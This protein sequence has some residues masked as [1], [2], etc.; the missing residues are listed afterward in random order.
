MKTRTLQI[1]AGLAVFATA[2]AATGL[3]VKTGLWEVTYT[4]RV[5]GSLIPKDVLDAMPPDRRAKVEQAM[6]A[7]SNAPPQPHKNQT[8][9]TEDDL[10]KGA[11]DPEADSSCQKAVVSQTAAH[12]EITMQCKDQHGT[13]TGHM[14]L[15]ATNEETIKGKVEIVTAEGKINTQVDGRWLDATCPDPAK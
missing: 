11:F 6:K 5:E 15:D 3:K 8:C 7:R 12:Q 14:T 4:T 10:A 1:A 2:F 13:R 9:V